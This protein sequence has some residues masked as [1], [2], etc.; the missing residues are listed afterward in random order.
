MHDTTLIMTVLLITHYHL[1]SLIL[2]DIL[3]SLDSLPEPLSDPM[4][5]R[6]HACNAIVNT[7][8]LA[9][10]YDRYSADDTPYGSRLLFD[11]TPELMVEVLSQAGKAVLTLHKAGKV[12]V[13]SAQIMLSVNF[14]ALK[15]LSN[16]SMTASFVL[17]SLEHIS[18]KGNLRTKTDS[19]ASSKGPVARGKDMEWLAKCDSRAIDDFLQETQIQ[20]NMDP[21]YL[22]KII[23]KYEVARSP[24]RTTQ[25]A[26][27]SNLDDVFA[28]CSHASDASPGTYQASV[29]VANWLTPTSIETALSR[30]DS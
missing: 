30:D 13:S 28:F 26:T 23:R 18:A 9:M 25:K 5:T 22:D 1:G 6:L 21:Q 4:S 29:N 3:D 7:L 16:I 8:T 20:A 12:D 19:E 24:A 27:Y 2:A 14:S 17:S 11:P 10:N 15:V